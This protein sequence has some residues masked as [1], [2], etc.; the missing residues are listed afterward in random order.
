MTEHIKVD[1]WFVLCGFLLCRPR[2]CKEKEIKK[3]N[4]SINIHQLSPR[5]KIVS[6][7]K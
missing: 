5:V 4:E 2:S 1:S 3:Q 6:G 7:T